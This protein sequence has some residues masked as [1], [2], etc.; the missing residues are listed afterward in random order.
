[1]AIMIN[2]SFPHHPDPPSGFPK[3]HNYPDNKHSG[4]SGD[5]H[6]KITPQKE[7][8]DIYDGKICEIKKDK[9]TTLMIFILKRLI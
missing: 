9:C 2:E 5:D 1:M 4:S 7:D 3:C 8:D 6:D